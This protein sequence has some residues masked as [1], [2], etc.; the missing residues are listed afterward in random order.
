MDPEPALRSRRSFLDLVI[1]LG[2][3]G[4]TVS[5]LYPVSRYLIPPVQGGPGTRSVVIDPDDPEQLDPETGIFVL[6]NRP[7]IL[8]KGPGGGWKAFSAICT[9]LSCTV[10]FQAETNQIWCPCHNGYFDL[11]GRNLPGSPPPRPLEEFEVHERE[12][13]DGKKTLLISKARSA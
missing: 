10:R 6:G 5:I 11:N 2:F 3:T 12:D 4:L 8:V 1:G 13:E 7:G 9:H